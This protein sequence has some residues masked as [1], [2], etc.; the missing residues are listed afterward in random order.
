MN[1]RLDRANS[2]SQRV[3]MSQWQL[4]FL[5]SKVNGAAY[6]GEK[7]PQYKWGWPKDTWLQNRLA[8]IRNLTRQQAQ[9]VQ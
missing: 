4:I 7:L 3:K 5:Q 9:P 6:R 1:T 8:Q 2:S